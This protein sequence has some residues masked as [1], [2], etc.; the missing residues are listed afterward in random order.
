VQTVLS[1]LWTGRVRPLAAKGR[2][3]PLPDG[4]QLL[5]YDSVPREWAAGDWIAMLVHGLGGSHHS[6][7]VRRTTAALLGEGFRV[8]RVNLRGAG[9]SLPLA[10]KLYHGGTSFDVRAAA[11]DVTRLAPGS[12]LVLIGLSLGG[13]VVL[14]LAGEAAADPLP[15]LAGVATV[16][17]PIDLV[18]CAQLLA[19]PGNRLYERYYVTK[20]V[21][22]V[23][24]HRTLF[25]DL[26]RVD[27]PR[28]LSLRGFDDLHTA[29]TW[30]FTDALDYYR[31][32]SALPWV[33]QI[34][35]PAFLLTARDDPFIAAEPFA[36]IPPN[37]LHEVHVL[38]R[39]GHLGFL[40]PDGAGGFRWG[41]RRVIDWMVALRA[42]RL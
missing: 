11:E 25:P 3:V 30:G 18:R 37:P 16:S 13:N 33:A 31:R 20:L 27:F 32:A 19:A 42:G 2:R 5:V 17:A 12:P 36:E 39:G 23:R 4:D 6:G 15:Q 1:T 8:V 29:P 41:E 22:Q 40:G 35:V 7:S 21:A 34:G 14:K 26:P 9:P 10:R 38:D 28:G 24:R